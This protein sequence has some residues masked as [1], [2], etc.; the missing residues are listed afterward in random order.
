MEQKTIPTLETERLIL[1]PVVIDDADDMFLYAKTYQVT[2]MTRFKPHQSVEDSKKVIEHVFL[3]RP[4]KG[5]P[6]AFAITLKNNGRMI[7]TCDFWPISASEG[8]YEMGYALNPRFWGLGLMTEAAS[9]VLQFAFESYKV[10]RMELKHLQS[11]PASGAVAKKLG[12]EQEGIKR[13]A[14]RLEDGYDDL[15]CYGLLQ[16]EYY[17]RK[18]IEKI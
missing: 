7:G 1:R 18:T 2:R 6:E 11:N 4:E 17:D 13:Q 9:A 5:W 15:V 8:V 10:R 14:A 3:S 16:E 12:F